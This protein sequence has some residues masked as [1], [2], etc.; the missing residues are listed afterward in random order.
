MANTKIQWSDRTWNC[1]IG[2]SKVSQ[3]CKHCY[4]ERQA[5]SVL[6]RLRTTAKSPRGLATVD[7]YEQ[8][9]DLSGETPRWSG[10]AVPMLHKLFEPLTWRKPQL[11]FVNSMSDVFHPSVPFEFIS[12]MFGVMAAASHLTFQILTKH[13][14]RALEWHRWVVNTN[15]NYNPLLE[16][17]FWALQ[18]EQRLSE[19]FDCSMPMHRHK[20]ADPDGPWPLP[21]VW[22]GVSVEDQITAEQRIPQLLKL[23]AHV[24]WVSFEPALEYVDFWPWISKDDSRLE[25]ITTGGEGGPKDLPSI[26]EDDPRLDWIVVGG[27]SGS[28]ARPFCLSWAAS[29]I[30]QGQSHGV[31]VFV[32]QLGAHPAEII[33]KGH[34]LKDCHGGDPREWPAGL[35]VRQFPKDYTKEQTELVQCIT[36]APK[37]D[38]ERLR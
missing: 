22:I 31:P 19:K 8:A 6:R 16:S 20:S 33:A 7:A 24:R 18:H 23:P 13:P 4:A 17:V 32:K 2:C 34:K 14:E 28:K 21:N 10:C 30:Y 1:L 35:N 9:L 15:E 27:E 25:W 11:V 37:A 36:P 12:A 38:D 3:G 29:V 26:P 5:P